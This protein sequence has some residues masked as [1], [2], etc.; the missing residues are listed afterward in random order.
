MKKIRA[1]HLGCIAATLMFI[2]GILFTLNIIPF[3]VIVAEGAVLLFIGVPLI[4]HIEKIEEKAWEEQ[5]A[6]Y[7]ESVKHITLEQIIA[8]PDILQGINAMS[9]NKLRWIIEENKDKESVKIMKDT[10]EKNKAIE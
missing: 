8:N 10:V 7:Y 9:V 6:V 5:V 2:S 4:H 3:A 1:Y